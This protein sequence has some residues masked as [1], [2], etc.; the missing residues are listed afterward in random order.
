MQNFDDLDDYQIEDISKN[1]KKKK[2]N[3]KRKG[4]RT[5]LDLTKLLT[6]RFKSSFSRTVGSGSRWS[7]AALPKHAMEV[8]SGDLVV[9]K[10]FKF[11]IESKGGYDSIDLGSVFIDGNRELDNFLQQA[12]DDAARAG[13]KPMLCWKRTRKPWIAFVL[14]K[15]MPHNDYKYTIKYREWTGVLLEYLLESPDEYFMNQSA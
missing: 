15:D 8:F 2:V 13:R 3:G 7:Q 14:T 12:T 11:A 5:E 4:S 9:P 1:K 6:N 10:G